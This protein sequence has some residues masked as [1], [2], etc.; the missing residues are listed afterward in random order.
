MI[1]KKRQS[2]NVMQ[3][4]S[5]LVDMEYEPRNGE[6]N[7]IHQRLV[8]GR[9]EFEQAATKT[10]DA[11]IHMSSM[12]LTLETNV[13]AVEKINTSISTAVDALSISADS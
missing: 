8:K 9:K 3:S 11:V 4:I 6:W 12:D 10:M 13:A 5:R 2:E 1:M 7:L